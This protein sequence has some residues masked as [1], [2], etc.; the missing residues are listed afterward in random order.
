MLH[1][2][3][4]LIL[5]YVRAAE[6]GEVPFNHEILREACALCHC[7]PVLSTDKFKTDFYDVSDPKTGG[8]SPKPGGVPKTKGVVPTG[9]PSP[10]EGVWGGSGPRIGA[11]PP[12][13]GC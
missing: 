3:V 11:I 7:L 10:Y 9:S 6:A 8:G 12:C 2:R 5:E 4:R 1:S 13:Y